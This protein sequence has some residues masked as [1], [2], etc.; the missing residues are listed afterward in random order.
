MLG[1]GGSHG[2]LDHCDRSGEARHLVTVHAHLQHPELSTLGLVHHGARHLLWYNILRLRHDNLYT[3]LRALAARCRWSLQGP[4]RPRD[5]L[6]GAQFI[7]GRL[8]AGA[9][10]AMAMEATDASEEQAL[11][12]ADVQPWNS[13]STSATTPAACS[14]PLTLSTGIWASCATAFTLPSIPRRTPPQ[15]TQHR[16]SSVSSSFGSVS[17]WLACRQWPPSS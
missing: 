7:L 8:C 15:A 2:L 5:W 17:S 6:H 1:C 11:D 16:A 9:A 12:H 4:R 3:T 13:V 10:H 14:L